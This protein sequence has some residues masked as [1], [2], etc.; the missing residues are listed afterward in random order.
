[1]LNEYYDRETN[2]KP[3]GQQSGDQIGKLVVVLYDVKIYNFHFCIFFLDHLMKF[4]DCNG[5]FVFDREGGKYE[6][7]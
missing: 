2:V 1:M 5:D 4:P 3:P 7:D 6:L